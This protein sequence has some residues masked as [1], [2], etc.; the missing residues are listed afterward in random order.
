MSILVGWGERGGTFFFLTAGAE[1]CRKTHKIPCT[2]DRWKMETQDGNSGY[3]VCRALLLDVLKPFAS[4]GSVK[5]DSALRLSDVRDLRLSDVRKT[6]GDWSRQVGI[7]GIGCVR[8][9]VLYS[10]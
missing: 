10:E 4:R 6:G 1:W 7:G 8:G 2:R 3:V 5:T 9:L